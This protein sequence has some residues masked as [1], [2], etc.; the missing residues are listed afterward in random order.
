MEGTWSNIARRETQRRP[1]EKPPPVLA[2]TRQEGNQKPHRQRHDRCA[3]LIDR[4]TEAFPKLIKRIR[5]E[6]D[7]N[8]I[9][10]RIASRRQAKSGGVI[11]QVRG[12]QQAAHVVRNEII[13]VADEANVKTIQRREFIEIRGMDVL[14]TK[15]ELAEVI[16]RELG[17]N[18]ND[19]SVINLRRTYGET[20]TS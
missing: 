19:V 15:E 7:Q 12:D 9:G 2:G 3:V 14:T 18:T 5:S 6:A 4:G 10:D 11:I 8:V 1:P 13:K 17:T 20:Q 16:A